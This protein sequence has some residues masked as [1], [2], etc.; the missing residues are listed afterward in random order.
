[1]NLRESTAVK[2]KQAEQMPF[3]QRMV[4]GELT[5][6][7][8]LNYLYQIQEIFYT[9]ENIVDIPED[10]KRSSNID[11]DTYE[12]EENVLYE[13]NAKLLICK[14]TNRYV[15]YLK[16]LDAEKIMP[17][18]YLNYMALMFGG[19][20]LKSKVPGSGKIYEFENIQESMQ[21]I[22]VKQSDDWSDDVNKGFDYLIGIFDELEIH[23]H[24]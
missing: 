18:V 13:N 15:D 5:D 8:Y 7:E 14:S 20:I 10:L 11:V 4:K 19:Q 1:M 23:K 2:H 22:R 21:Y 6:E 24:V 3:N 17:H 12:L 9:I 16:T